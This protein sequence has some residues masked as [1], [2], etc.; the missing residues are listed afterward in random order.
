[1]VYIIDMGMF[2]IVKI[3]KVCVKCG[4]SLEWQS[5]FL[6]LDDLYVLDN[7]LKTYVFDNRLSGEIHS[8]CDK[9]GLEQN[10]YIK[11]GKVT[12]KTKDTDSLHVRTVTVLKE[13][14]KRLL[15]EKVK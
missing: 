1:M 11:D 6:V 14:L 12:K 7:A 13:S 15:E 4:R 5:K 9:C 10:L 2:N 8:W 3:N